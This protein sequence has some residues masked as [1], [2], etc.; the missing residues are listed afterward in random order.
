VIRRALP[1]FRICRMLVTRALVL[2]VF[3][4]AIAVAITMAAAA[5]TAA[6][7]MARPAGLAAAF[8]V[9]VTTWLAYLDAVRRH[10][11][12][13]LQNLG[14]PRRTVVLLGAVPAA[15]AEVLAV[16]ATAG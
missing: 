7:G 6:A 5:G 2:W 16:V 4:H 13:F 11:V 8:V 10:E 1:D 3:V 15:C 12:L 14:V 9:V